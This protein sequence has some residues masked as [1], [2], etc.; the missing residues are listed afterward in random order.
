MK[1]LLISLA[2]C[3][4]SVTLLAADNTA[5]HLNKFKNKIQ[6]YNDNKAAATEQVKYQIRYAQYKLKNLHLIKDR[7]LR[8]EIAED[9]RNHLNEMHK[10][11]AKIKQGKLYALPKL[12]LSRNNISQLTVGDIGVLMPTAY[13][14]MAK[15]A[16]DGEGIGELKIKSRRNRHKKIVVVTINI[17]CYLKGFDLSEK[18]D[19]NIVETPTLIY[20]SGAKKLS[21]GRTLPVISPFDHMI[22]RK[23]RANLFIPPKIP[24]QERHYFGAFFSLGY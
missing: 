16:E 14:V 9:A 2:V 10:S 17:D 19:G 3:L 23:D 24:E 1:L 12:S 15:K 22:T 18:V 4:Q 7:S 21:N 6:E 11:L 8:A 5:K 20:V 13:I